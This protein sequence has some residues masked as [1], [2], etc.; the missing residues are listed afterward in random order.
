MFQRLQT[1]M[2]DTNKKTTDFETMDSSI[3]N[4]WICSFD[5]WKKEKHI[6]PNGGLIVIYH[7]TIYLNNHS[8][9][10]K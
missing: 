5:A 1:K 10:T 9:Q 3:P 4:V 6:L 2:G 7:A 8:T